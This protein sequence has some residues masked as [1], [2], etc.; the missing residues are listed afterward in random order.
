MPEESCAGAWC[1]ESVESPPACSVCLNKLQHTIARGWI[2]FSARLFSRAHAGL[3][4]FS[5]P[6]L[7]GGHR[8][9]ARS[10]ET[11][12]YL[13]P[14]RCVTVSESWQRKVKKQELARTQTR[15]WPT[16]WHV[17]SSVNCPLAAIAPRDFAHAM[18][19]WSNESFVN[20]LGEM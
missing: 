8:V 17:P 6:R 4:S 19:L 20:A 5:G 13:K 3:Q 2:R 11:P 15:N 14:I 1:G 9:S 18:M 7:Q 16:Q 12:S 10:Y